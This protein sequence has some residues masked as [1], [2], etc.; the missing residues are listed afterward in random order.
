MSMSAKKMLGR[1]ALVVA[2]AAAVLVVA[3]VRVHAAFDAYLKIEGVDG[4]SKD[5]AHMGWIKVKSVVAGDLNGDAM[6]DRESSAPSASELSMR[7]AGGDP[8]SANIGSQSSGAGAVK[9]AASRDSATGQASRRRMH[10]PF[11]ITK[12]IDASSPK[13]AELA[14]TG[15]L[16]HEVDVEMENGRFKLSNVTISSIQRMGAMSSGGDRPMESISFAY[17]KI[18]MK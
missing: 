18:E 17:Q 9:A 15:R 13:L 7:K 2:A 4:G 10:K 8:K 5:P 14:R 12:E 6:A 1:C 16:I 11:V 3:Q